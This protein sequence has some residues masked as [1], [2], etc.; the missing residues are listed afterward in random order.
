MVIGIGLVCI[1]FMD[2]EW[3]DAI[4]EAINSWESNVVCGRE[5][6]FYNWFWV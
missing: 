6:L 1:W 2:R 4:W 3:M 5:E